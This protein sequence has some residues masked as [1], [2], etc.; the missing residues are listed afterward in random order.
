MDNRDSV[1]FRLRRAVRLPRSVRARTTAAATLV[2]G[3]A[4]AIS[5]VA[6]VALLRSQLVSSVVV[7]AR[8]ES[9]SLVSLVQG[10]ELP[11]PLPIPRGDI[12]AQVVS[13]QGRVVAFT[14]NLV[15]HGSLYRFPASPGSPAVEV[16]RQTT[17]PID[18][19]G[20]RDHSFVLVAQRVGVTVP[21]VTQL[22]KTYAGMLSAANGRASTTTS[23]GKIVTFTNQP[24]N[25]YV[26]VWASLQAVDQSARALALIL[27]LGLPL[28]LGVVLISTWIVTKRAFLP[29]ERIRIDVDEISGSNPSRRVFEPQDD[30]EIGRLAHTMNR[31]LDR[32]QTATEERKRFIAD[33]SH[34]LKSPLSALR[35]SLEISLRH[36][37][38]ADWTSA[39]RSALAESQRMQHII[40][41]LLVLAKADA[42]QLITKFDVVDL[43]DLVAEEA[44]RLKQ[45]SSIRLEMTGMS[46]GRVRGDAER[47]RSVVRNLLENAVRHAT[48][49]VA[50][51][52]FQRNGEVIFEVID[53]G[54]GIPQ[55]ERE[56][57]FERFT[58][59]DESRSRDVGGSGL[60]LAIVKSIV[61][62]HG[63]R[64]E[65]SDG[66]EGCRGA[67][68]TV[69]FA[70]DSESLLEPVGITEVRDLR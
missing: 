57:I 62:A 38:S 66:I 56:S 31:M 29:V 61:V 70:A 25:Y 60:G 17:L 15:G 37:E 10:G 11:N 12:A 8:N 53:D 6:L 69:V 26:Y 45:I 16:I 27:L 13:S 49:K 21:I 65:V 39:A 51:I 28:L 4:L 50:V 68:F 14:Q 46:A 35:T 19:M 40:E 2:V 41:D 63:G 58:R 32:L 30:D 5:S 42:G 36:P 33:A 47:L 20:D 55:S 43:D 54:K 52:L 1:F 3:S 34:E 18:Q 44:T 7:T 64:V 48:Q 24:G 67:R 59:L 9:V 23:T 22:N